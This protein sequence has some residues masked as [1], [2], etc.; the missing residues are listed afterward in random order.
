MKPSLLFFIRT[1]SQD[2]T[3]QILAVNK[4]KDVINKG[5]KM[6]E[7]SNVSIFMTRLRN[8]KVGTN[9]I[10]KMAERLRLGGNRTG[11]KRN[12]NIV[13]QLMRIKASDAEEE[14][15]TATSKFR[16]AKRSL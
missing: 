16:R 13:E 7:A 10:E 14:R 9:E 8:K 5:I 15:V 2:T 3:D 12:P 1:L 11:T 4:M 6:T